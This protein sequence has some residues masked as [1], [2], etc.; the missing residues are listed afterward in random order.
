MGEDFQLGVHRLLSSLQ[1]AKKKKC[2]RFR[3]WVYFHL[4]IEAS[5]G[6]MGVT[7]PP[8]GVT[9]EETCRS[10]AQR[11]GITLSPGSP[12][13]RLTAFLSSSQLPPA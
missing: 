7:Y 5:L 12:N 11:P 10:T 2:L 1:A 9:T 13:Q 4:K 3:G 8:P 6:T